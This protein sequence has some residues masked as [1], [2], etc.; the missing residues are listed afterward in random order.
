MHVGKKDSR[1]WTG[2]AIN[3]L[4]KSLDVVKV[5]DDKGT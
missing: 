4:R 1:A 3:F 2:D 5:A